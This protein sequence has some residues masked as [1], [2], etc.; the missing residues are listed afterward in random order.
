M[1]NLGTEFGERRHS[2]VS[3]VSFERQNPARPAQLVNLRYDDERGLAA[4]GI[5]LSSLGRRFV[6]D[7]HE[8]EAFPVSR[9]AQPPR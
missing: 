9:F 6:R 7:R 3:E 1:N 2:A 8:P 5:D 4:R